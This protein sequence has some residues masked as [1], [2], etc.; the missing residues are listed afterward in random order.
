MDAGLAIFEC[1]PSASRFLTATLQS[2]MCETIV[3]K[4]FILRECKSPAPSFC[5]TWM[6]VMMSAIQMGP[7]S[8]LL[9]QWH[10]HVTSAIT[11]SLSLPPVIIFEFR[12]NKC[13]KRTLFQNYIWSFMAKEHYSIHIHYLSLGQCKQTNK[14][15]GFILQVIKGSWKDPTSQSVLK[16]PYSHPCELCY[17]YNQQSIIK[18]NQ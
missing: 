6:T 1:S 16:R 7:V 10:K 9:R 15:L 3:A 2:L 13:W 8:Y 12:G 14:K 5:Q 18:C 4:R 17:N 11:S